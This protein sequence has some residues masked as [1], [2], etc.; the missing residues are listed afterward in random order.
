MPQYQ[1]L[2]KTAVGAVVCQTVRQL[3]YLVF[4]PVAY[5]ICKIQ[6]KDNDEVG[7]VAY[8]NKACEQLFGLIY[9]SVSS[10]WGWSVLRDCEMLPWYLGGPSDA[11]FGKTPVNTIFL[12]Y[13]QEMLDYSLYT[14]GYHFGDLLQHLFLDERVNDFEEML[15]HH[16][17]AVSLYFCY[18][19]GNVVPFGAV[20]AYLHDIADI[21][22][23]MSKGLNCTTF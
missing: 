4:Y 16:I 11:Q 19:F 7:R 14:Y 12:A 6:D 5:R 20:I 17:A 1:D 10:Y 15:L 18:I 2:W 13:S 8:S 22:G 23:R 9:F 21:F 3:V